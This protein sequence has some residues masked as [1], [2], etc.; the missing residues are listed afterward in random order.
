MNFLDA[1]KDKFGTN[2]D[3]L[4]KAVLEL[5]MLTVSAHQVAEVSYDRY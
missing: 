4:T 2:C 3:F 1:T 5:L